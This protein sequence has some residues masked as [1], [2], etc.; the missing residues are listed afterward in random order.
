MTPR[1]LNL[2]LSGAK[3][4]ESRFY[5]SR[6]HHPA[7]HTESGDVIYFKRPAKGIEA[8]AIAGTVRIFLALDDTQLADIYWMYGDRIC[9]DDVFWRENRYSV[10][11]I[12]IEITGLERISIP[13][14]NLPSSREGWIT[15][16][17]PFAAT[18]K[19]DRDRCK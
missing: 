10:Q 1:V 5:S 2:L 13:K 11:C 16:D 8:K 6:R 14:G 3:T 19:G 15:R 17:E 4:I 9:A 7:M 18:E 12:L